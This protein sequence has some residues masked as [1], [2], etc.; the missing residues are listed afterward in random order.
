MSEA[1]AKIKAAENSP[2]YFLDRALDPLRAFLDDP[3]GR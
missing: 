3:D 1:F 2:Y